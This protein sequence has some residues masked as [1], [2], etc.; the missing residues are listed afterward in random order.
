MDAMKETKVTLNLYGDDAETVVSIL[1][2]LDRAIKFGQKIVISESSESDDVE[3]LDSE[4][5][6]VLTKL[7]QT[8]RI[9]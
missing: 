1:D 6:G 7:A 8:L 4:Q 9:L 5:Y 2:T 3:V